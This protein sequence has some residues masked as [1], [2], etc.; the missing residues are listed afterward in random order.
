MDAFD[1]RAD[2]YLL[3]THTR[4]STIWVNRHNHISNGHHHS[5]QTCI[6]ALTRIIKAR[7]RWEKRQAKVLKKVRT[8]MVNQENSDTGRSWSDVWG[9]PPRDQ[10]N[11]EEASE[12]AKRAAAAARR[13]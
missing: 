3:S 9:S 7:A 13:W 4:C 11:E 2:E 10:N 12:R 6:T 8:R 1:P 5:Q